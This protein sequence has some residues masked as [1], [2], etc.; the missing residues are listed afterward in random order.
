[1]IRARISRILPFIEAGPGAAPRSRRPVARRPRLGDALAS[2]HRPSLVGRE[3]VHPCGRLA[4]RRSAFSGLLARRVQPAR[5]RP[6]VRAAFGGTRLTKI[7]SSSIPA[8]HA[9]IFF[10]HPP[11]I[12]PARRRPRPQPRRTRPQRRR[13][14][15]PGLLRR[16][17]L[18]PGATAPCACLFS[19]S[20]PKGPARTQ[21]GSLPSGDLVGSAGHAHLPPGGL[22]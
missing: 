22:R 18:L 2:A 12:P 3:L 5:P 7:P 11:R 17:T 19:S 8:D 15:S 14:G 13:H 4:P 20:R 16:S 9:A 10:W 21:A 1:M 6:F